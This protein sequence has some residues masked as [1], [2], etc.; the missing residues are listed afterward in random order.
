MT[1]TIETVQVKFM[2]P[3]RAYKLGQIV[4]V[5]KGV[6]RSLQ[7]SRLAQPF[8]QPQLEL[9]V[10]P[11]PFAIETALAPVAKAPRRRRAAT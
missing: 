4:T 2:R 9:A 3:F 1:S 7:L 8:I 5:T 10:A 11:E 6:A